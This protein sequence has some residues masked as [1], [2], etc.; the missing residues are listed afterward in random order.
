MVLV[1]VVIKIF[2]PV[3]KPIVPI[4]TISLSCHSSEWG[5]KE[6]EG[7]DEFRVSHVRSMF[8]GCRKKDFLR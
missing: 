2:M 8:P 3:V 5:D 4:A 1:A 6:G 7:E